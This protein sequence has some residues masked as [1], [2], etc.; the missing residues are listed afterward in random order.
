MYYNIDLCNY[1]Y[2]S[3]TTEIAYSGYERLNVVFKVHI[4]SIWSA[5]L[6]KT[7]SGSIQ[8]QGVL[9]QTNSVLFQNCSFNS[10]QPQLVG[11][12]GRPSTHS[13]FLSTKYKLGNKKIILIFDVC[14]WDQRNAVWMG[15]L[16]ARTF[17]IIIFFS[18]K[19]K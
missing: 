2:R 17:D 7:F 4:C 14:W 8:F 13:V 10:A 12:H 15:L 1:K 16:F 19:G 3:I 9:V 11:R 6:Y 18:F 5:Y